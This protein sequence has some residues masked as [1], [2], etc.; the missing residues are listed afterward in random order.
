M[1]S[2]YVLLRVPLVDTLD[3]RFSAD[4]GVSLGAIMPRGRADGRF[5]CVL[6][7]G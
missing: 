7:L 1:V 5:V 4:D 6:A 3:T 2:L